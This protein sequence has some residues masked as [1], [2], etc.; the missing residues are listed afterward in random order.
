MKKITFLIVLIIYSLSCI[1]QQTSI[2]N[3]VN[4][5]LPATSKKL[6][7]T[8]TSV[9]AKRKFSDDKLA[10]DN[11]NNVNPDQTYTVDDVLITLF[12]G[13]KKVPENYLLDTKKGLD[14]MS[15]KDRSYT[16]GIKIINNNHVLIIGETS[17]NVGYYRFFCHNAQHS[18]ALNGVLQFSI[19][20]K[21]KATKILDDILEGVEFTK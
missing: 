21:P 14:E 3:T 10:L 20:D 5:K 8:E 2:N 11:A 9:F 17:G 6:S 4:I 13:N 12:D 1:G 7:K 18:K 16:S 15:K 19:N